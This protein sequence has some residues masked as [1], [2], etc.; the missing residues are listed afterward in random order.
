MPAGQPS[1]GVIAGLLDQG[2]RCDSES[3]YRE[4]GQQRFRANLAWAGVMG[5]TGLAVGQ[6]GHVREKA[7][8]S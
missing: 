7:A 4:T 1:A 5:A 6:A 2:I 3:A 8:V